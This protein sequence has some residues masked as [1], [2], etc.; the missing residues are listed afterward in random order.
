MTGTLNIESVAESLVDAKPR[1]YSDAET[2]LA[3]ILAIYDAGTRFLRDRF[4]R[5]QRQ[6]RLDGPV[7]ACYPYVKISSATH[8]RAD[9][10]LSYGFV[11]V[12]D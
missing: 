9:T 4:A 3:R 11:S 6:G 5:Y 12:R 10:R 7:R 8:S 1:T 2:A